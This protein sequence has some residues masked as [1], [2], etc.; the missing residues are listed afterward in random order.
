MALQEE[1]LA[2]QLALETDIAEAEANRVVEDKKSDAKKISVTETGHIDAGG[3]AS[4]A[5]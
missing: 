5:G 4:T 2:R 1:S 3:G